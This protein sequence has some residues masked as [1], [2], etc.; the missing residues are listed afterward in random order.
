MKYLALVSFFIFGTFSN[1]ND[2]NI[3]DSDLK[4][5]ET[6]D[7]ELL[8]TFGD[9]P[10]AENENSEALNEALNNVE[11][12][13]VPPPHR[14][15]PGPRTFPRP[16]PGPYPRGPFPRGPVYPRTYPRPYP[17]P[18]PIP[19]PRPSSVMCYAD[20]EYGQRFTGWGY[21]ASEA[22]QNALNECYRYSRICYARGC[23]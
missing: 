22:Q 14:P 1:A 15:V 16:Y 12:G 10:A 19:F 2:V 20:N 8:E 6:I 5:A 7:R 3:S 9:T 18:V 13:I 21:W 4:D 11:P 23:Y 17:I